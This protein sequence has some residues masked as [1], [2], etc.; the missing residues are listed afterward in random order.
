M[1]RHYLQL[2]KIKQHTQTIYGDISDLHSNIA[3][4]AVTEERSTIDNVSAFKSLVEFFSPSTI[5][6]SVHLITFKQMTNLQPFQV[7]TYLHKLS[8]HFNN[9]IWEGK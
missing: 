1:F 5:D 4:R 2:E 9:R 3:T 7:K 6:H 8:K